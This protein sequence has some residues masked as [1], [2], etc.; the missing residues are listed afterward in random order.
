MGSRLKPAVLA[1]WPLYLRS[2]RIWQRNRRK[3]LPTHVQWAWMS[4]TDTRVKTGENAEPRLRLT[5]LSR[6]RR[7]STDP[8]PYTSVPWP[9]SKIRLVVILPGDDARIHWRMHTAEVHSIKSLR[10][11]EKSRTYKDCSI[12]GTVRRWPR[13]Y[14]VVEGYFVW[15]TASWGYSVSAQNDYR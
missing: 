6:H 12:H 1:L 5:R 4:Y 13:L 2:W 10:I 15:R 7:C 8:Y 14:Y 11:D 9:S 3:Q